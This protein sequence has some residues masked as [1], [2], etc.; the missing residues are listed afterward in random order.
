MTN[1]KKMDEKIVIFKLN[2]FDGN[3]PELT[4]KPSIKKSKGV[5]KKRDHQQ[6][7]ENA[8]MDAVE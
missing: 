4:V 3:I 1:K 8:R 5:N 2:S 6:D 7:L